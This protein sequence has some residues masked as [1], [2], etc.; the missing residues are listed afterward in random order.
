M[1]KKLLLTLLFFTF[2]L[3]CLYSQVTVGSSLSAIEGALLDLKEQSGESTATKGLLLPRVELKTLNPASGKLSESIGN[4]GTWN[5]DSHK[6]LVV[7]NAVNTLDACNGGA[8]IGIYTWDGNKWR[9]VYQQKTKVP[10][11]SVSTDAYEG[12]NSY[13]VSTNSSVVI[14]LARA[15]KIWNDFGGNSPANGK[16]LD[17]TTAVA[18]L[19]GALTA[20][21]VWQDAG[22]ISTVNI[23][24]TGAT[25]ATGLTA[26]LEVSTGASEG[27]ALVQ[28]LISGKVLWQW[29]IWVSNDNPLED[30]QIYRVD[31]VEN[32][33]MN[34]LLGASSS[35]DTGLYYQWGRNVPMKRTGDIETISATTAERDN[36]TNAIQSEK[37]ILYNSLSSQDWYSSTVK[38]W[39]SRW[40][41][42]G[43]TTGKSPFDPCPYGWRVPTI[44]SPNKP[45]ECLDNSSN[46]Q[47]DFLTSVLTGYRSNANGSIGDVGVAGYVWTADASGKMAN[48]IYYKGSAKNNTD[49]FNRANAM[50]V[51]CIK[52]N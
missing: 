34:R 51:R 2:C 29:H 50:N 27:N 42:T 5:G 19:A 40:S 15:I 3:H 9:P 7:Y 44:A 8:Y 12:A 47:S 38:Q 37:F 36:L 20:N 46:T 31:G 32:W 25:G 10:V 18:G 48:M 11:T 4:T 43:L 35:F 17:K 21:I 22:T 23:S 30:A 26:N 14:P 41:S 28:V 6:G 13:I 16:V 49:T 24:P 1:Q 52:E 39:D 33:Y 45:L